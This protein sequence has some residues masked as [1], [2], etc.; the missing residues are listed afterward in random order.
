MTHLQ[1]GVDGPSRALAE[2][3][4]DYGPGADRLRRP[5]AD[6]LG[7]RGLP[8]TR[9]ELDAL[10]ADLCERLRVAGERGLPGPQLA[11]ELGLP[12]T[13]ALRL[14]VAYGRLQRQVHQL[15]GIP[16][17]RYYW[18]DARPELYERAIQD[19]ERRGLDHLAIAGVHRRRPG[20]QLALDFVG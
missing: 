15:V 17:G 13:R 5:P 1:Q 14:L 19:N 7:Q 11:R 9:T 10:L 8:D 12:G 6:P 3:A 2:R 16:G 18:G 20:G 4:D